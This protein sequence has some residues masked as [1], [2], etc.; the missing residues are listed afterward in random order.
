MQC[1]S[2]RTIE[3]DVSWDQLAGALAQ[4]PKLLGLVVA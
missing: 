1:Q 4:K 2:Y 3:L